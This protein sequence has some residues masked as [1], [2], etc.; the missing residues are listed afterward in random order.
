MVAF[1]PNGSNRG[2]LGSISHN[3]GARAVPATNSTT[4]EVAREPSVAPQVAIIPDGIELPI[5][6]AQGVDLTHGDQGK[7]G[8]LVDV[9]GIV[10]VPEHGELGELGVESEAAGAG[11]VLVAAPSSA[12]APPVVLPR[13]PDMVRLAN[14]MPRRGIR[15][16]RTDER[17]Y[18]SDL[19]AGCVT[20][21]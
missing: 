12:S 15:V 9:P 8:V 16:C 21:L 19:C 2:S 7:L 11:E 20:E 4:S 1:P 3:S 14:C 18:F 5:V 10:E 17:R 6:G 13:P